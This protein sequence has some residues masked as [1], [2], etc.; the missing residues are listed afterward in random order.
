MSSVKYRLLWALWWFYARFAPDYCRRFQ[1]VR[2]SV[3]RYGEN[4]RLD[5]GVALGWIAY[6]REYRKLEVAHGN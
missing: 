5:C 4:K 3:W 1:F 6:N 2:C